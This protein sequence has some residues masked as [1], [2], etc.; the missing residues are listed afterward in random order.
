MTSETFS[1]SSKLG[2]S[3]TPCAEEGGPDHRLLETWTVSGLYAPRLAHTGLLHTFLLLSCRCLNQLPPVPASPCSPTA[4]TLLLTSPLWAFLPCFS[5]CS[6]PLPTRV[7]LQ[8]LALALL[9]EQAQEGRVQRLAMHR[10]DSRT[11]GVESS[12]DAEKVIQMLRTRGLP[13]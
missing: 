6:E 5:T 7:P 11:M 12:W 13:E 2:L 4:G 9:G 3:C 8:P 1:T 10:P